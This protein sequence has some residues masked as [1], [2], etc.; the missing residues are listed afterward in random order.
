ML[1][2]A[3]L[4]PFQP[5]GTSWIDPGVRTTH[6]PSKLITIRARDRFFEHLGISPS[7]TVREETRERSL[8][9][10]ALATCL[11][12]A[13]LSW[14]AL[15]PSAVSLEQWRHLI[16]ALRSERPR[17]VA[18]SST[19][20]ND[21]FWLGALCAFVREI[22]PESRIA[23]GGYY[24]ATSAKEFLALDADI[25]C[26][27]EGE[28]RIVSISKAVR[29]GRGL[30]SI[31]GLYLRDGKNRL[32]YTGDVEPL[33]LDDVPLPDWSLSTRIDPPVDLRSHAIP[34]HVETQRGCVFKCQFCTYRTLA[35]PVLGT[36]E[37]GVTAILDAARGRGNVWLID[38]TATYPRDR[39]R[40]L[41]EALIARGGS[42][43]P[44][45]V[46]ARANDLDDEV[47]A[48]MA[49]AGVRFVLIG[50]ESGDQRIL[51][52]IRKGTR[53][54]DLR[55]AIAALGKY[56]IEP[57]LSFFY[58]F[59]G[60]TEETMATTRRLIATINDDHRSAP[61]VRGITV[62]PMTLQDFAGVRD[63]MSED[64]NT[65]RY[66]WSGFG[67]SATRAADAALE[68]HI[69]LS[70]IPHAPTTGF[71]GIVPLHQIW[72]GKRTGN[73]L[74]YFHWVKAIDRGIGLFVIEAIEG[75]KPNALEL[76]E[77]R[78]QVLERL[79][80]DVLRPSPWQR[81]V[82]RAKHRATWQ[83]LAEWA[84]E[85][86]RATGPLTRLALGREALHATGDARL[87]L[88]AI[89]SARFPEIGFLSQDEDA[90]ECTVA[91]EQLVQ[92]GVATGA[93][94]LVRA[95]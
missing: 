39:W 92:L 55:P 4:V 86:Q 8:T 21:A 46:Y 93:R 57:S 9:A 65:P 24:Y 75:R 79:P 23:V 48:L 22:L 13:G 74:S 1:D 14:R 84:R 33:R 25:Y 35:A 77:V 19:F 29:D 15:D 59:P 51:N 43:L 32:R 44:M 42:P 16:A 80:R 45:H 58:G 70:R 62:H 41:L 68:A 87:A 63:R 7:N 20:V 6:G 28:V 60:E 18:I 3:L 82:S 11:E 94:R 56:G 36:V 78:G 67:V 27:G 66:D 71:D 10:V 53:V 72:L 31:P 88:R 89:R 12:R 26:V 38:S 54:S 61:V 50:Q 47:C 64:G 34:Y 91:A 95:G 2:I 69:E 83:V 90:R 17:L 73:D 5:K 52:A 85:G 40:K 76:K 30:D 37:R 49:R 81:V